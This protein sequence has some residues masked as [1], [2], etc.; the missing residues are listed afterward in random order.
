MAT[1]DVMVPTT[2]SHRITFARVLRSEWIKLTTLR[3]TW[4]TAAAVLLVIVGF[5]SVAAMVASGEIT[6][7]DGS[8]APGPAGMQTDPVS[9]VLA[10]ANLALLV[11]AVLGSVIGA[12]EFATGMIRTTFSAVP[13]RLPSLWGKV[14]SFLVVVAP[15]VLIGVLAAFFLG[16]ALLSADDA[17]TVAWSDAGV[18]RSVLGTAGNVV[19]IGVIGLALG[20]LLRSTAAAIGAVL[21]AVMFLPA[22]ASALLPDSWDEVLKYL[23]SN[24]ASAFTGSTQGGGA[25]LEPWIGALVFTAWIVVALIAAAWA[26]LRRDA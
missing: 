6:T 8:T 9:T 7:P 1:T 12:R 25:T 10:G 22:L 13:T 2:S 21:G 11:V 24:A 18:A 23:P 5:G 26:L 19:G 14:I 4:I 15:T 20:V 16:M 17:A 3:S